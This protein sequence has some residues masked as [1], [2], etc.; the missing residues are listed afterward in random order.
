MIKKKI[1]I[2]GEETEIILRGPKE[3]MRDFAE[4]VV[5]NKALENEKILNYLIEGNLKLIKERIK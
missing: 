3:I 1:I 2:N 5:I 4:E